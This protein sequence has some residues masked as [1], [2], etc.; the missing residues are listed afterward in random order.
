MAIVV[1]VGLPAAAVAVRAQSASFAPADGQ[2][3]DGTLETAVEPADAAVEPQA[4]ADGDLGDDGNLAVAL[5]PDAAPIDDA[6]VGL[7]DQQ[8]ADAA[9]LVDAPDAGRPDAKLRELNDEAA[10][11][12]APIGLRSGSFLFNPAVSADVVAT[13]NV[14]QLSTDRSSDIVVEVRPSLGDPV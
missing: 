6:G 3:V 2:I 4:P 10:D 8:A 13:D 12:F 11:P 1:A 7:A 14:R 9:M 5:D